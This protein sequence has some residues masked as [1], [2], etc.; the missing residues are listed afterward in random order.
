MHKSEIFVIIKFKVLDMK[1]HKNFEAFTEKFLKY[2][3]HNEF[4]FLN[5]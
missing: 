2:K 3:S 1:I 4:Y 5:S